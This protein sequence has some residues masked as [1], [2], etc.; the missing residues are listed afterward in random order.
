MIRQTNSLTSVGQATA[1]K[2]SMPASS[3]LLLRLDRHGGRSIREQLADQIR[4]AVLTG[5]LKRGDRLP[6]TR[7]LADEIGVSRLTIVESYDQLLA[8]GYLEARRGSGTYVAVSSGEAVESARGVDQPSEAGDAVT[9][10]GRPER[11]AWATRLERMVPDAEIPTDDAAPPAY[12]FRPGVGAWEELAWARWR[13]ISAGVWRDATRPDLWY[14]D[15]FGP[16]SLRAVLVD[17]LGRSRAVRCGPEQVAITNGAQQAFALLTRIVLDQGDVACVEDPGY[18][19]VRS[20]LRAEGAV[21]HPLPVDRDG[22]RTDALPARA[23]IV[24]VT[25]SH[26]YPLGP[27]LSLP[28]RLELLSWA[29][30]TGALIVEDDYDGEL[31]L[32]GHRLPS[33]QGLD[34]GQR[35]AYVGTLSKALFPSLRLGFVVLPPHLVETFRPARFVLDR[36]PPWHEA[37]T[38]ARFV[39]SGDLERHVHRLRRVYRE[40]RD[41]LRESLAEAFGDAIEI[42][43][44]ETGGHLA[45]ILPPGTDDRA[46]VDA[47]RSC[48]VGASPL[49]SFYLA[50]GRPGLVLGFGGIAAN[51][52]SEGVRRLARAMHRM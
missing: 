34:G 8:E 29:R 26:Q 18:P 13:R 28:R 10:Q 25:P 5:R 6:P 11:S 16:A 47:A 45:I 43:P 12:D 35:V 44:C 33:L 51:H 22:A 30:A 52:I 27:T 38:V 40:R 19:R 7:R 3:D 49:S 23:R 42:G 36:Q 21:L 20:A 39:E 24:H 2:A 31:H 48:G 4:E 41:T 14:A 15:P 37:V 9:G 1:G 46:L 17:W 50:E 32:E